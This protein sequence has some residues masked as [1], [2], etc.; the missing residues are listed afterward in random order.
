MSS[1]LNWL[2]LLKSPRHTLIE[3]TAG[4]LV[5]LCVGLHPP[6]TRTSYAPTSLAVTLLT[7]NVFVD[8][9]L[10]WPP[11]KIGRPLRRQ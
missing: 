3:S 7:V 11:L 9:P 2:S 5:T 8:T 10:K 4:L 6:L 1:V